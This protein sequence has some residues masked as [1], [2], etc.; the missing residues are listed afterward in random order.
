MHPGRSVGHG[1]A[2]HPPRRADLGLADR[3]VNDLALGF[4]GANLYAATDLGV[5][6]LPLR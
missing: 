5:F 1:V 2:I 3:E 4:D 6:R